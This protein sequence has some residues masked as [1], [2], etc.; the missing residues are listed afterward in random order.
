MNT[1][2][3]SRLYIIFTILYDDVN[4]SVSLAKN[5]IPRCVM[6]LIN[7]KVGRDRR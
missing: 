1:L 3:T 2:G 7:L 5:A 4:G 6:V